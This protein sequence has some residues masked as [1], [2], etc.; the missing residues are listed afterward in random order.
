VEIADHSLAIGLPV[1]KRTKALKR[2]LES[3]DGAAIDRAIIAD[4]G[5]I[6]TRSSLYEDDWNFELTVLDLEYD[7]G[8]GA[9]RS[10]I[11]DEL[12]EDYLVI[13]DNDM[14]I[15]PARELRHLLR[16]LKHDSN[17]GAVSGV[18]VE[19]NRIRSG[20]SN[21]HERTLLNGETFLLQS[22]ESEP[23]IEWVDPT[24]P[25]ARF[26][27]LTNAAIIQSECLDDYSWDKRLPDREHLD[28]YLGHYH[29]TEWEFAVCPV[30][31]FDH[32][33]GR[34]QKYRTKVR[35]NSEHHEENLELASDIYAK[36]WG[37][38]RVEYGA[39]ADWIDTEEKSI[40]ERVYRN[41]NRYIPAKFILPFKDTIEA[42]K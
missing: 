3:I 1:F 21:L 41:M 39:R 22:I 31:V 14:I 16:T 40:L 20:C 26:D 15:P 10:A 38:S 13:A 11:N 4:N 18:V 9:C 36:K 34:Y 24:L 37:Y 2:C 5:N 25:I 33:K 27:K 17:L 30:V 7:S 42:I 35:A 28:L 29:R 19:N 12:T 8:I 6:D 32:Q 23:I